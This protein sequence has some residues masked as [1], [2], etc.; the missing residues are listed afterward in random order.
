MDT[1]TMLLIA[2]VVGLSF[3]IGLVVGLVTSLRRRA[4]SRLIRRVNATIT[5]IQVEAS[6]RSCWWTITAA[7]TDPLTRQRYHFCS[8]HL[9]SHPQQRVGEQIA[10]EF[11]ATEP[12]DYLMEL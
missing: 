9:H 11:N 8:P 3:L 1:H 6:S 7:W 10:V 4:R 2:A 5:H 12:E